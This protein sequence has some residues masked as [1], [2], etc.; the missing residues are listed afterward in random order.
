M[1]H[2]PVHSGSVTSPAWR[3]L[4]AGVLVAWTSLAVPAYGACSSTDTC[5][6][7]IEAAQRDTRTITAEFTQI[8]RVSLLDEPL[9]SSGRM[10]FK[11]PDHVL[12][13][14]QQ[15]QQTRVVIAGADIHIPNLPESERQGL[16]MAPM[17][18]MFTQLGA[19]FTG[20][21]SELRA[22][23]EVTA[24]AAGDGVDVHLVPRDAA[25]QRLF[26]TVDVRFAGP[27]LLVRSIGL[28]DG[29]GDSL[30]I[31][32]RNVQR[33]TEVPDATFSHD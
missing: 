3:G 18:T 20:A 8:K 13:E 14:I 27:D 30:E 5:L 6:Q 17:A 23:F 4:I 12:L 33:N 24:R 7:A 11:R 26:R 29:L 16:S 28:A 21:T 19:I 10:V 22:G 31:T 32:L 2:Q 15:P 25:W 1:H 9:T